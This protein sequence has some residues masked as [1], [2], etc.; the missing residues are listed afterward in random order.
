MS[1]TFVVGFPR[2]GEQRELKWVLED[3]WSKKVPFS[4]VSEVAS[5]LRERHI[6]SQKDA[7]ID[8]I[9]SNDFS[10]YDGMLDTSIMLGAVPK[11]FSD[12]EGEALYFAMARGDD[13]H[14]ALQMKKWFN[15]NYH[16][17]VPELSRDDS[18]KLDASKI[19]SEYK[20][21]KEMGVKTKINIIGPITYTALSKRDDGGDVFELFA[22]IV[23][24]YEELFESIAKLDDEVIV[25][26]EEPI[27]AKDLDVKVLSL[28]KPTYDRLCKVS[29]NI[30][31]AL[32]TYFDHSNEATKIL[33]HT[34]IWAIGL[35]LVHG[36]KNLD[37]LDLVAKSDK[38][39][40]AGVVDGRNI[41]IND[42]QKSLG[43]LERIASS[44]SKDRIII[45][46]SSSLLHTPYS[47]KQESE[48]SSEI[49]SQLSFATEKLGEIALLAKTFFTPNAL[50]ED[51]KKLLETNRDLIT[52]RKNSPHIHSSSVQTRVKN[53]TKLSRSSD[54]ITRLAKQREALGYDT[55]VTTT[56]GS[57]PQT[58]ELRTARAS[59][60]NGTLSYN[61]YEQIIKS[62]I[63]EVI[64][65]QEECGLDVLVHGEGERVDMVEYFATMLGG[66]AITKNG[67]V[68]SYGSRCVK[69]PLIY[70]DVSRD[71][72]MTLKWILYAQSR[73]D[74]IVKGMLTGPV[75]MLNWSFVRDDIPASEVAAQIALAISDEV[76]DL[77][78]SGI[79]IIQVDE[80][81]F[82][83][84]YP[85][86]KA[87]VASYEKW[88]KDSFKLSV[89]S[90]DE[91]T[92][93]HTHMCYSEFSDILKTIDEMDAD[94]ISIETARG[95]NELLKVFNDFGYKK[96]LGLGVYDIHSP[97]VPSV[98][99]LKKQILLLLQSVPK[100]QI[101][102]N[103]DCGLKT[104]GFKEVEE[105]L[106]N[107][108][109]AVREIKATL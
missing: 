15:T 37:S 63:D 97:R 54:A 13:S 10:L 27:F 48:L 45:S 20:D 98:E 76:D 102:I 39:L 47:L 75:T 32:L 56:I 101:W 14:K 79:K 57:F 40:I 25:Q 60:K 19:A 67:W 69:P 7:D 108:T 16:Y 70:G 49:K 106:A 26:V 82:K 58:K 78:K 35:D 51:D 90:A 42:L 36:S 52:K 91:L 55:L 62:Y 89:S 80:A 85:L 28:I 72:P 86:R 33:V 6:L 88:A 87:D 103:P 17:L 8:L 3:F 2:I 99:E 64:A 66:F 83:E 46:S 68:Q 5:K 93:I 65:L 31:V 50:N 41:W 74:K 105:S 21:A 44:I 29:S 96:E 1:K 109:R 23:T 12:L 84:G 77:Q 53:L 24:I 104:R 11:R 18:Y 34:P 94:V 95:A 59:F 107:M 81:A 30:K 4:S 22:K 9:S 92:Q 61:E 71:E 43:L 73:T 38:L 100:E